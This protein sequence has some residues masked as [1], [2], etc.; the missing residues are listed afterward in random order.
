MKKTKVYVACA[1]TYASDEFKNSIE[2]FKERLRKESNLI[3]LDF[4]G[5]A[6]PDEDQSSGEIY[7]HDIHVCVEN[8]EIILAECSYPSTGLG[9]ELGTAVEK[10]K[11][12]VLAIAEKDA[13]VT[14]LALG[15][16]CARNPSF[17]FKR[18]ENI[19]DMIPVLQKMIHELGLG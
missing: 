11:I 7:E 9:W 5:P 18:Y 15:A 8:S 4:Y 10:R 17:A 1:L 13:L 2:I 6:G 14:E 19:L 12:P 16:E 3:I